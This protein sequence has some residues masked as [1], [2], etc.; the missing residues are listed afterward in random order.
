M[1]FPGIV[2]SLN[3]SESNKTYFS[4]RASTLSIAL[5]ELCNLFCVKYRYISLKYGL[6][7][8]PTSISFMVTGRCVPLIP[9]LA[10][11]SKFCSCLFVLVNIS[12]SDCW[13]WS[14]LPILVALVIEICQVFHKF[15]ILYLP[16]MKNFPQIPY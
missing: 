2:I 7:K 6:F 4:A 16:D 14:N 3:S 10:W 12:V 13:Y 5:F 1:Q 11:F 15:L 9:F 8:Y